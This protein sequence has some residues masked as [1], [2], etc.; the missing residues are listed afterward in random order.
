MSTK[1]ILG[2]T[3]FAALFIIV[4]IAVMLLTS[5]LMRDND[6][7]KLPDISV[8]SE[9]PGVTAP[10]ALDRVE[11]TRDTIQAVISTLSR[12]EI[13]SRN[14]YIE[15]YW[16]GGK[17]EYTINVSVYNGVTSLQSLSASGPEKRVIVTPETSYIWYTGETAPYAGNTTGGRV[18]DYKNAD[19]WQ[20]LVTYEDVLNYDKN[21]I[22][23]AGTVK[24]GEQDCVY[25]ICRSPLLGY[26]CK[27]Y[28]SIALGLV[29]GAEEYDETGALVYSMS[30]GECVDE[31][32][33]ALF[34]LPDGTP[35]VEIA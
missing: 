10:D 32:D 28:I 19:E 29:T 7:V 35:L 26:T 25:A 4:L 2:I 13:Y 1:R 21:D 31:V 18:G 20:M 17:A 23:E 16:E 8:P 3:V 33:P 24:Y 27:Y 30:A 6:A 15:S 34:I 5:Y 14:M 22:I 12:P 11:V 9:N